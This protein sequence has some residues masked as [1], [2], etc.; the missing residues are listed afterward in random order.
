MPLNKESHGI[1]NQLTA[2]VLLVLFCLLL[3]NGMNAASSLDIHNMDQFDEDAH[4]GQQL[5]RPVQVTLLGPGPKLVSTAPN[6]SIKEP[7]EGDTVVWNVTITN[8]GDVAS[9]PSEMSWLRDGEKLKNETVP[10]I[11][12]GMSYES[13]WSRKAVNSCTISVVMM[14]H[15][16]ESTSIEVIDNLPPLARISA[17]AKAKLNETVTFDARGSTDPEGGPLDYYWWFGDSKKFYSPVVNRSFNLST[18]YLVI[19]VVTDDLGHNN[20]A[21]VNIRILGTEKEKGFLP[22]FD[23]SMVLLVIISMVVLGHHRRQRSAH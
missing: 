15:F 4:G 2:V 5:T 22:A 16:N 18:S 23:A 19:L 3:L 8:I 20:T 9:V 14:N 21:S 1:P 12:P 7:K 11:S 10:S 17:P 6:P 13:Q